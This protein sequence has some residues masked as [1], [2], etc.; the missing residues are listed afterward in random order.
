MKVELLVRNA[1]ENDVMPVI[2]SPTSGFRE[3]SAAGEFRRP[4]EW[5]AGET[6]ALIGVV[7]SVA[8]LA[9]SI[10][11][12]LR[13]SSGVSIEVWPLDPGRKPIVI[14]KKDCTPAEIARQ[15]DE[16]IGSDRR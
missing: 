13:T 16:E 8:Q 10:Y 1:D 2:L 4:L 12:I 14:D 15:I 11:E 3:D 7:V 5:G 6:L 9:V